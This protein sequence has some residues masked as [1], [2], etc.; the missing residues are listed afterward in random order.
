MKHPVPTSDTDVL[1]VGAGPVGLG[2]AR[3]L[4]NRGHTVTVVERKAEPYPLPR[5][6]VFDDE[7]ARIFQDMGLSEEIAAVSAPVPDQYVWRNAAGDTLLSIDW[8]GTG[9][10]GW[11]VENFFSQPELERVLATAVGS[12]PGV[13][14]LRGFELVELQDRE[15]DVVVSC[16]GS[17]GPVELT[18]RFVV[19]CDGARSAVRELLGIPM[20]DLGFRYDWLIV[21]VI[22]LDESVWSPQNWQLCDPA[23]PTSVISGGI[24]RRRWEF[25]RLPDEDPAELNT[26]ERAWQLLEPWGRT[27]ANTRLERR[28]LYTFGARWAENWNVGHV[29]LAGDA[30]HQ[31][32]PFAGQG[33]CSGL[34]DAANL[35]WKLDLAL[36]GEASPALL[37]TYTSERIVHLRHAIMMSVALGR[38]ICVLDPAEADERDARMIAGGADPAVVLPPGEPPV[39]GPGALDPDPVSA[40]ARGT[41]SPQFPVTGGR[42][43]DVVGPGHVLLS[44]EPLPH[45]PS[46]AFS[47]TQLGD[48]TGAWD[49]WFAALGQDAVLLRPDH[50]IFGVSTA[51]HAHALAERYGAALQTTST[52]PA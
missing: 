32:P 14:V 41:L 25:M 5:A 2:L 40:A 49:Q 51:A 28:A 35:A 23:R 19:G 46:R 4:G 6:V 48:P 39:L 10:C 30:A 52:Q 33:M 8:S 45:P 44:R 34:R 37:D 47:I 20:A 27:P 42:F 12:T 16:R 15:D 36:S 11:P 26:D 1:I 21:D 17:E 9:P 3:L 43:D 18:A 13:T 22:P 29:A 50:Y 24:G 31:M 38:V 7:I